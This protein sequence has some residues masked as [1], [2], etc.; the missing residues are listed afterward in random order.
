MHCM[1]TPFDKENPRALI[2][3]LPRDLQKHLLA[4]DE[5]DYGIREEEFER[6]YGRV[7]IFT[8]RVRIEFWRE[9][10]MAQQEFRHMSL[11]NIA[12]RCGSPTSHINKVLTTGS[13][14]LWTLIPPSSYENFLDEALEFGLMRVRRDILDAPVYN[15]DGNFDTKAADLLLKAVAFFDMRRN[16][17]IVQKSVQIVKHQNELKT[18]TSGR[19]IKDIEERIKELE[20]KGVVNRALGITDSSIPQQPTVRDAIKSLE[21]HPEALIPEVMDE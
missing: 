7:D 17:G 2:N 4:I 1:T 9:Y 19:T 5:G 20:A 21:Q 14:L 3:L 12:F 6:K 16:G 10:E 11:E 15:A 13:K 8:N 18:L